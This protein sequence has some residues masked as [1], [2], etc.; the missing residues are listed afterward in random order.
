MIWQRSARLYAEG[1]YAGHV[2]AALKQGALG[3]EAVLIAKAGGVVEGRTETR[4]AP[5]SAFTSVADI[6][7]NELR[8]LQQGMWVRLVARQFSKVART[9]PLQSIAQ[10]AII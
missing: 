2:H 7:N 1:I 3:R 6:G 9:C 8:L 4:R 10:K 5:L